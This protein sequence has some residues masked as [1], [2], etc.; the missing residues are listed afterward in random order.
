MS[1]LLFL[2]VLVALPAFGWGLVPRRAA[3]WI[4]GPAHLAVAAGLGALALGTEMVAFSALGIRWTV[5]R[6][7]AGPLLLTALR[8]ARHRRDAGDAAPGWPRPGPVAAGA[9]AGGSPSPH[10][11]R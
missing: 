6:V 8:L 2:S 10:T 1:G 11:Q 4:P 7:A 9:F 3:S 5:V